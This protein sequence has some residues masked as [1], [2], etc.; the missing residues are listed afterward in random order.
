MSITYGVHSEVG[1]LRRAL[2]D[3]PDPATTL[4]HQ[5]SIAVH[6]EQL[7][8][9]GSRLKITRQGSCTGRDSPADPPQ[10]PTGPSR[11]WRPF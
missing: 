2:V 11:K 8:A 5:D 4:D 10:N 6:R 3:R 9:R 1:K 7:L